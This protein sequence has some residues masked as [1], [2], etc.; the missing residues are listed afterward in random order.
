MKV[1]FIGPY[2]D[3]TGYS[4]AGIE[5]IMSMHAAGIDVV[6]RPVKMTNTSGSI[7][8]EIE[9]F[10]S[11]DLKNVDVAF[12]YNLPSE[13]S[14][15]GGVKN[16]GAFAYETTNYLNSGWLEN[17]RLMDKIIVP[18]EDNAL[19]S[20]VLDKTAVVPH[21]VDITKFTKDHDLMD[22][23]L[24]K[25]AV[26]FYTISEFNRRKNI[27]ALIAAYLSTFTDDDNVIL[28]VKTHMANRDS[29]ATSAAMKELVN[30]F[31]H[32]LGRFADHRRYPKIALLTNY[33]P[34]NQIESLHATGD[35]F[36]SASHG[37][38]WCLPAVDALGFGNPVIGPDYGAFKDY[39][40]ED[41]NG[42][43]VSGMMSPV[44]GVME[45][46]RGLYTSDELWFN[47]DIGHLSE[48]MRVA[49]DNTNG[50]FGDDYKIKNHHSVKANY[51]REVVGNRMKEVLNAE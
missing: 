1:C 44:M 42:I 28:I 47:I 12:Q 45:A 3:G 22:F 4:K 8:K 51:S 17:L 27:P 11:K 18:C 6:T 29:A 14:Y 13:F 46:P 41:A 37:E 30:D 32:A 25:N 23:G 38:A 20:L 26:K 48:A 35:I 24:P 49:Y 10:E 34:D 9:E 2:R 36:V 31:K 50:V 40:V 15:K 33:M 7:P 43:L 19:S 16:V 21:S 5:Y 39:V